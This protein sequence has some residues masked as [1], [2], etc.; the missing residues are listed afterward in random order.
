V[1]AALSRIDE[2]AAGDYPF[3]DQ[4]A[5]A[6]SARILAYSA[7]PALGLEMTGRFQDQGWK[8]AALLEFVKATPIDALDPVLAQVNTLSNSRERASLKLAA[9]RRVDNVRREALIVEALPEALDGP[10]DLLH[11]DLLPDLA[12]ALC[13]FDVDQLRKLW[14][15]HAPV[16]AERDRRQMLTI[17][18]GLAPMLVKLNLGGPTVRALFDA[19]RWWP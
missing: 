11:D 19:Q 16:L 9:S 14:R 4:P 18:H 6:A 15:K 17:V 10:A 1:E 2:I 5:D 7:N 8:R 12:R 13:D 3:V